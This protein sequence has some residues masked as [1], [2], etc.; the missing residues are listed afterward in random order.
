MITPVISTPINVPMMT[1]QKVKL[2]QKK[3]TLVNVGFVH[4]TTYQQ[5]SIETTPL[6]SSIWYAMRVLLSL[7]VLEFATS[8][9]EPCEGW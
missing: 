7:S 4:Q 2:K 3:P 5:A 6:G 1:F 8:Q 9:H